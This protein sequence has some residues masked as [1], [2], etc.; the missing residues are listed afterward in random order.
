MMKTKHGMGSL[1]MVVRTLVLLVVSLSCFTAGGLAGE[2]VYGYTVAIEQMPLI[3]MLDEPD[4]AG[5][6]LFRYYPDVRIELLSEKEDDWI[7]VRVCNIDGYMKAA[8]VNFD[9]EL[10]KAPHKLPVSVIKG[11]TGEGTVNFRELPTLDIPPLGYHY[12]GDECHVLGI[13]E[14]WRHVSFRGRLG[15]MKTEYLEDTEEITEY[16]IGPFQSP[17]R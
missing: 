17:L 6:V 8:Q 15:F 3:D 10:A 7:H 13:G 14:E 4:D 11:K 16:V 2:P 5:N 9:P 1:R 12:T